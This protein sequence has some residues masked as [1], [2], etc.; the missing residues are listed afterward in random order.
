MVAIVDAREI[1]IDRSKSVI[2]KLIDDV[3][4]KESNQFVLITFENLMAKKP[5][6]AENG[7]ILSYVK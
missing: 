4:L 7:F 5:S 3:D 6:V 2:K 1:S